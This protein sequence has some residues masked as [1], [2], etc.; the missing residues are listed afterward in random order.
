M[1][2]RIFRVQIYPELRADFERD[3]NTI[4]VEA[5]KSH[6]TSLSCEIGYPTRWNPD[7]YTMITKWE[8]EEDLVAFAGENWNVSVIPDGM[9][10]YAKHHSVTHFLLK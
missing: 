8:K 1:I 5:V 3:F 4:S 7:E 2:I 10:K 9:G 6:K